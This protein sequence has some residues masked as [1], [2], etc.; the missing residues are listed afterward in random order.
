[1]EEVDAERKPTL[2]KLSDYILSSLSK[3][4]MAKMVIICTHNSRRSHM[5]QLWL[6]AAAEYYGVEN[7]YTYSGGTESTA[8][9]P[10]AVNALERAGFKIKQTSTSTTGKDNPTYEVSMGKKM[11]PM[12]LFSKRYDDAQNPDADFAAVMVCSEADESCPVVPGA[13]ARFSLPFDDPRYFDGTPSQDLKYDETTMLIAREMFY[14]MDRVK[15]QLVKQAEEK[16]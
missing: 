6:A 10:N 8:F 7:I 1:M 5:G 9:N 3:N 12:L 11:P 4:D 16:K 2:N 15:S 14:V 13:S